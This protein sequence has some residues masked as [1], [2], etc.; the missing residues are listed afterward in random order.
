[1]TK[2]LTQEIKDHIEK[3]LVWYEDEDVGDTLWFSKEEDLAQNKL[4]K[5]W[6]EE[7]EV[8]QCP[9]DEIMQACP[10][11]KEFTSVWKF[12]QELATVNAR[13]CIYCG[14]WF[15]Y[16][17]LHP[18]QGTQQMTKEEFRDFLREGLDTESEYRVAMQTLAATGEKRRGYV[19][20]N[21]N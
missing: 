4:A 17:H 16:F 7:Q 20:Q 1:M 10:C 14:E 9:R 15:I 6:L 12:P 18:T 5:A 11:C 3:A 19:A 8:D 21:T 2:V 13:K